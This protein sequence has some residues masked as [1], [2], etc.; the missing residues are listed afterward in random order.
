MFRETWESL[1]IFEISPF[2]HHTTFW[3]GRGIKICTKWL[4][5][6]RASA[7]IWS[8][9]CPVCF[10]RNRFEASSKC[11]AF[12]ELYQ[13]TW[14]PSQAQEFLSTA[15]F[16]EVSKHPMYRDIWESQPWIQQRSSTKQISWIRTNRSKSPSI[17]T[18]RMVFLGSIPQCKVV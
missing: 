9:A 12:R 7:I 15:L 1:S 6:A 10:G 16:S 4:H 17:L 2:R 14:Q 3:P 13:N 8:D 5:G 18:L 11:L